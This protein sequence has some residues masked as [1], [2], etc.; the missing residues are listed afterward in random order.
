[1]DS[2]VLLDPMH[3]QAR[4]GI[5]ISV[6]IQHA[7]VESCNCSLCHVPIARGVI[8]K[9]RRSDVFFLICDRCACRIGAAAKAEVLHCDRCVNRIGGAQT[10]IRD[11]TETSKRQAG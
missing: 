7:Q 1:M 9:I 11:L 5:R 2:P 4:K 8:A 6:E 10:P 3:R